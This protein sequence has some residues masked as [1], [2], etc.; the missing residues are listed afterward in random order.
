MSLFLVPNKAANMLIMHN[1]YQI[2][3]KWTFS[4]CTNSLMLHG[5]ALTDWGCYH[6]AFAC[7]YKGCQ[8]ID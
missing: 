5:R 7:A 4:Q 8:Y 2:T 6:V 3:S 1:S